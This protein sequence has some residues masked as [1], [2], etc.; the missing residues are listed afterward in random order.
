MFAAAAAA[1]GGAAVPPPVSP[2]LARSLAR[3]ILPP[4]QIKGG[5]G[6]G[7][8]PPF[9]QCRRHRRHRSPSRRENRA[10]QRS[11]LVS[12]RRRGGRPE[13]APRPGRGGRGWR[14]GC[15]L[16]LQPAALVCA[17]RGGAASPSAPARP[18]SRRGCGPRPRPGSAGAEEGRRKGSEEKKK[19]PL[20]VA[21][22]SP[23]ASPPARKV[24]AAPGA[25][26][27][28]SGGP[29]ELPPRP[30]PPGPRRPGR[31]LFANCAHFVGL[32]PPGLRSSITW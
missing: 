29:A 25:G 26:G 28:E 31:V 30:R 12:P 17:G 6:K 22:P 13:R 10:P 11:R 9:S 4:L 19:R 1:G 18:F 5:E 32:N 24:R 2:A 20:P 14:P 7:A 15:G 23:S 8:R 16:G 27:E 21:F 3:S